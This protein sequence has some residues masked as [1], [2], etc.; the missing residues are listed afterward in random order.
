M[1]NIP[2]FA[3]IYDTKGKSKNANEEVR[4]LT[5]IQELE[6]MERSK[7]GL[8]KDKSVAEKRV[9]ECAGVISTQKDRFEKL[10][11]KFSQLMASM[12]FAGELAMV[13]TEKQVRR[14]KEFSKICQLAFR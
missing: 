12:S 10:S 3:Q 9:R 11:S 1:V 5:A 14:F 7:V 8:E 6:N 4:Y 13:E 2:W